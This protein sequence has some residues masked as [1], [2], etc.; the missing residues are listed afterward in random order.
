ME[1]PHSPACLSVFEPIADLQRPADALIPDLIVFG[2][3]FALR[4]PWLNSKVP[5]PKF[6]GFRH[7]LLV[8]QSAKVHRKN[9]TD[10]LREVP[11]ILVLLALHTVNTPPQFT[12][13]IGAQKCDFHSSRRLVLAP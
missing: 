3:E 2:M 7:G 10:D 8:R 5:R 9:V 12:A 4:S 6:G 1:K 13:V 11:N